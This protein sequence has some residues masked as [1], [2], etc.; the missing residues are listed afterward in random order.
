MKVRAVLLPHSHWDREWY[1]PF[2]VFRD[3]LVDLI[4]GV[5]HGLAHEPG[6]THF[7]L[8]GQA[9]MLDDY[10]AVRP[11]RES[12]VRA[13]V[14]AGRLSIGPFYTLADEFLVSGESIYR[15]LEWGMGRAQQ[16]GAPSPADGP[17]AGYMPDQFGHI[18][19][20]PQILRAFGIEHAVILR[21][22]PASIGTS[23]FRWRAPDGSEVLTEYL[24]HGY[25]PGADIDLPLTIDDRAHEMR[26]AIELVASVSPR[27]TV[28]LPVGADHW[29]P[30]P[31]MFERAVETSALVDA[32]VEIGSLARFLALAETPADLPVWQGEL[33]AASTWI[34]LPNTVATRAYQKRRRGILETRLERYAEPLSALVPGV[35]WPAHDLERAWDLM[36]QNTAHDSAY[37]A[38]GDATARDVDARFNTVQQIIDPIITRGMQTLAKRSS[39]E[40]VLRFNPSPFRRQGVDG[41]SWSV[42]RPEDVARFEPRPVELSVSGHTITLP[43]GVAIRFTDEDDE[44]DLFT[45]SPA[46]EARSPAVKSDGATTRVTF[47]GVEIDV[48]A[49]LADGEEHVRLH[50][51]IEN[52][53]ENHRLRLRVKLPSAPVGSAALAPFEIVHRELVGEGFESEVG[54]VT[55]PASGAVLAAGTALLGEGV[56][57]YEVDGAEL[58]VTLL[59]SAGQIAKPSVATRPIWAGPSIDAPEGQCLGVSEVEFGVRADCAVDELVPAWE[60]FALP[61]LSVPTPGSGDSVPGTLA[62]IEGAQLSS[63]RLIDGRTTVRVWNDDVTHSR[64]ASIDGTEVTLGAAEIRQIALQSDE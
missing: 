3:K 56:F 58:A 41:L 51:R 46:G 47:L 48:S 21:G 35:G 20:F 10:L 57:E 34:L 26:T 5:L 24:I 52:H 12:E 63:V 55:W 54:S 40:G 15:N 32:D 50:L 62:S 27:S 29:A 23:V 42:D 7:H 2:S 17:W 13:L 28:L 61:L 36:L 30:V 49:S 38:G 19:Q 37:G 64:L 1:E 4:D 9:I 59:R 25:Y 60:T 14:E 8:D 18:G 45:F 39:I 16:W 43:N 22:V 33:R 31:G 6:F 44:G 11:E 53:R